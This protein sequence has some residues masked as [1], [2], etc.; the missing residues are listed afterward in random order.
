MSRFD[1]CFAR[2]IGEEGG[3]SNDALDPGGET[4]FGISK[5]SFPAEDIRNLT[6]ERAKAIYKAR[7]WDRIRGDELP[8]PL[9]EF[10]FDFAVNSGVD[11]AAE[12]LQGS[13]GALRDGAIG[14]KTIEAVKGKKP[15]EVIRLMF[16][17]RA[18]IFALSPNDKRFGRGWFARLF[19]KTWE[20][21]K[22][23]A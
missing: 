5:R 6:L 8:V 18:M 22:E 3:Y 21:C 4:K 10:T 15:R 1:D 20:A 16:V 7:Y 9:D 13:V 17:D 2:V 12:S 11:A 14:S 19:D 23:A